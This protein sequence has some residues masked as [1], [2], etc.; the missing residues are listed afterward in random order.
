MLNYVDKK[1]TFVV[2]CSQQKSDIC[3]TSAKSSRVHNVL[4]RLRPRYTSR[5]NCEH[6]I[7][8]FKSVDLLVTI[9]ELLDDR[10][11]SPFNLKHSSHSV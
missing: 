9:A 7:I 10:D 6:S 4:S 3:G 5:S 2:C 1:Q 8:R 11:T